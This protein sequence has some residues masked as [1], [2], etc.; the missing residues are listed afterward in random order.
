MKRVSV[1][2]LQRTT[3]ICYLYLRKSKH[4]KPGLSK[5]TRMGRCGSSLHTTGLWHMGTLVDTPL[6]D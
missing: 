5:M 6:G 2:H 3:A 1:G 4:P